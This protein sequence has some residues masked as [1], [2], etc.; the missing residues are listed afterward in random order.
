MICMVVCEADV[1]GQGISKSAEVFEESDIT[2]ILL[3]LCKVIMEP[4][5]LRTLLPLP[6]MLGFPVTPPEL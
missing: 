6:M 1:E 5:R 4:R 3:P 2:Y